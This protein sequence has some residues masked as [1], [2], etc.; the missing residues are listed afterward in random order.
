MGMGWRTAGGGWRISNWGVCAA[1][2][3]RVR[4]GSVKGAGQYASYQGSLILPVDRALP[5]QN[6][7]EDPIR[8]GSLRWALTSLRPLASLPAGG[9]LAPARSLK[10]MG[11]PVEMTSAALLLPPIWPRKLCFCSLCLPNQ[12]CA[13]QSLVKQQDEPRRKRSGAVQILPWRPCTAAASLSISFPSQRSLAS[14]EKIK[15]RT[16][17]GLKMSNSQ[18]TQ[19]AVSAD[20]GPLGGN[21]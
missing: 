4:G 16:E 14:E 17:Y 21:D 2:A 13:L 18:E 12:R 10:A 20:Q 19:L 1:K 11:T 7:V 8:S 3:Q 5:D 9:P 6:A 15:Y